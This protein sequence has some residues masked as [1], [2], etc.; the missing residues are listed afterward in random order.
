MAWAHVHTEL[1]AAAPARP[2]SSDEFSGSS[3]SL[4]TDPGGGSWL[5]RGPGPGRSPTEGYRDYAGSSWNVSPVQDPADDPFSVSRSVLTITARR[6]PGVPGTGEA[7]WLSGYLV[8][9]ASRGL[10]WRSGYIEWR[11]A[12]PDPVRG[13]FPALWLHNA[14]AS[15]TA[16]KAQAEIDALEIFGDRSGQPWI[17][18]LHGGAAVAPT[19]YRTGTYHDDTA[20][21]HRYGLLWIPTKIAWYKDGSLRSEVTGAA[22]HWFSSVAMDVRMDL[23]MDPNWFGGA[24]RSTAT[25]PAPGVVPRLLVDYVRVWSGLPAHLPKGP[26]DP[27]HAGGPDQVPLA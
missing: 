27:L 25:D 21:W 6:N 7:A 8:S 20:H 16:T 13:M 24:N 2:L 1:R 14:D 15:P 3:L 11:V 19:G 9:D 4:A 10:A 23:V 26:T 5:T 17:T 12:L 22:A 18:A